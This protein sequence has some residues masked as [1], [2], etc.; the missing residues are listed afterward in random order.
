MRGWK[1]KIES[2]Y[3]GPDREEL[4][5]LPIVDVASMPYGDNNH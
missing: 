4:G 5:P 3:R 2:D 1:E